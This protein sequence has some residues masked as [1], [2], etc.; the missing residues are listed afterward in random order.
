[1]FEDLE[2]EISSFIEENGRDLKFKIGDKL[3]P[4]NFDCTPTVSY[5]FLIL[6][7]N[8]EYSFLNPE[9]NKETSEKFKGLSDAQIYFQRIQKICKSS[10]KD[11][12]NNTFFFQTISPNKNLKEVTEFIFSQKLQPEQIPSFI[13]IRL[14]EN[15]LS[16]KAPRIFGFIGNASIIYILFYDP[17][18]KIFNAVGKI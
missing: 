16:N 5:D 18:H 2:D 10:F 1:M 17:F 4:F 6:D 15:K 3:L 9:F 12:T 11:L 7:P 14:Y 8:S 13:E